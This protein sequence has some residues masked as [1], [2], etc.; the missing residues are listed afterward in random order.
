ML[1]LDK[2]ISWYAPHLC[3]GCDR[4]GFVLCPECSDTLPAAVK[5]CYRCHKADPDSRTC[6]AC[7]RESGLYRVRIV[8]RYEGAAKDTLWRLKFGYARSA[9][10]EVARVMAPLFAGVK[11]SGALIVHVPTA[12]G[13]VRMRGYD[14]AALI[15]G[16]VARNAHLRH[17]TLLVRHGQHR[18]V[19]LHRQQ[20]LQQ[21][22]RAFQVRD[23]NLV[24]NAHIVLVDDVVTTGAT[25]E[26]AA[27]ALKTAGAKRVEAIVFAQA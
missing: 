1:I 20:R 17:A 14:Q 4:E 10:A 15:A 24:R 21:M 5:R 12:S 19:G 9:A 6:A 3:V 2:L 8:S 27:K 22:E 13:R 7:R 18:Q 16:A 23:V 25:L 11:D 26:S